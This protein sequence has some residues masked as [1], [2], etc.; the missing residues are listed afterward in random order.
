MDL[1]PVDAGNMERE[2]FIPLTRYVKESGF[3]VIT[4]LNIQ[5][6]FHVSGYNDYQKI[7]V[8]K[9]KSIGRGN[10]SG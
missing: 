2:R 6:F 1:L 4:I 8:P 9:K 7:A 10:Y 3:R 5:H